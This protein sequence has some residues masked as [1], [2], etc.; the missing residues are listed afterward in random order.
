MLCELCQC[1]EAVNFHHFIPRTLHSNKWSKKRFTRE[2]MAD[3]IET[4][5]QC[6]TAIHE[7][8]PDAKQLGRDH[9]SLDKLLEH[10]EIAKYVAWK[11]SRA[12][13]P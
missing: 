8:V 11:Q 4:C 5:P 13:R 12:V 1:D 7:L 3:G 10:P 2:Q 9:N 6:H